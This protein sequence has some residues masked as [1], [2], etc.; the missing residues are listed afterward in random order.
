MVT[1]VFDKMEVMCYALC[2]LSNYCYISF[3]TFVDSLY[4]KWT[5]T[6]I[7]QALQFYGHKSHHY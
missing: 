2:S 1:T 6:V 3:Y 4:N 5:T 7:V